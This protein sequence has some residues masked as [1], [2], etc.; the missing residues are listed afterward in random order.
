VSRRILITCWGSY[1]DL[2]PSLALG[3]RL[4]ALGHAPVI[5]TVPYYREIVE[6]EGLGFHAAGPDIDP[7]DSVTIT[8]A[9][10]PAHGTEVIVRELLVPQV[11]KGVGDLLP[12]VRQADLVLSHPIT[13]ATPLAA[14]AAGVPWLST[15]LAPTSF[16]SVHDFPLLPPYP[17]LVRLARLGPW[18][19]R[20]FLGLARRI[21]GP[22]TEPVRALRRELG[23]APTGDPLYEGQFSPLGTLA[24]FSPLFGPPQPDWP[25][26]TCATGF[27]FHDERTP[28]PPEVSRFLDSGDPPVVFTLGSSAA[29]APG[30]F[31]EE[32]ARAAAL[33][34]R[35]ALLLVGKYAKPLAENR[36][37]ML[38]VPYV[39]HAE[40]F[41]RAAAV[42]HHGGIGTMARAL[43]SGRPMLVVPHAHDQPDN[44]FRAGRLGV[45]RV[46][47]ARRYSAARAAD[48]LDRLLGDASYAE[49]AAR[50]ARRLGDE[51]GVNAAAAAVVAA[52]G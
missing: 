43:E 29:G 12:A 8:R 27:L 25:P 45:A 16:F 38:A 17:G 11:R 35:R 47:D 36:G 48:A 44:A 2:F 37:T 51:H 26:H 21:T 15:V 13:F 7:G 49:R 18:F 10:D 52:L 42:V 4:R 46:L 6:R 30:R 14:E 3:V 32:S 1:G 28:A 22:W 19:A 31:Y 5:A 24:F 41:A 40:V 33:L 20:A 34:N 9:M 39:P 50:L 23:L